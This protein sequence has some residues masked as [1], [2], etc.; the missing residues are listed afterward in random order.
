MFVQ[1]KNWIAGNLANWRTANMN[2]L[3]AGE[4]E[5]FGGLPGKSRHG[6]VVQKTHRSSRTSKDGDGKKKLGLRTT[7]SSLFPTRIPQCSPSRGR[8]SAQ[9][10]NSSSPS[11]SVDN[12]RATSISK[13]IIPSPVIMTTE[14]REKNRIV[15]SSPERKPLV[16]SCSSSLAKSVAV[17][18]IP[19]PKSSASLD[20]IKRNQF[21]PEARRVIRSHSHSSSSPTASGI[22]MFKEPSRP[23]LEAAD[24][25][26]SSPMRQVKRSQTARDIPIA[27]RFQEFG[28]D[29]SHN[30][31]DYSSH[32]PH[33]LVSATYRIPNKNSI[34][35]FDLFKKENK[36]DSFSDISYD[37]ASK[38]DLISGLPDMKLQESKP[39]APSSPVQD[40]TREGVSKVSI[41]IQVA[42][43]K[44][45]SPIQVEGALEEERFPHD[46]ERRLSEDRDFSEKIKELNALLVD[47]EKNSKATSCDVQKDTPKAIE[48][49]KKETAKQ[50]SVKDKSTSQK[51]S[52]NRR[53]RKKSK[54]GQETS[55]VYLNAFEDFSDVRTRDRLMKGYN[56]SSSDEE[57]APNVQKADIRLRNHDQLHALHR[58]RREH[59]KGVVKDKD[60]VW[61]NCSSRTRAS[62]VDRSEFFYRFGEKEK[63]AVASFDFLDQLCTSAVSSPVE[64]I[65]DSLSC[66]IM[67]MEDTLAPE[68]LYEELDFKPKILEDSP[69]NLTLRAD[70]KFSELEKLEEQLKKT[71]LNGE[72]EVE[73]VST[74]NEKNHDTWFNP[75]LCET[76]EQLIAALASEGSSV[77]SQV[78]RICLSDSCA[79]SIYGSDSERS[80]RS[81]ENM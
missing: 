10:S 17:S 42:V 71:I 12:V 76:E 64:E 16:K 50:K 80:L 26:Q 60:V 4:A 49:D 78:G 3:E 19:Q 15:K 47:H 53:S 8:S 20:Q 13:S 28:C 51:K 32:L 79:E 59:K 39:E 27:R 34:L 81:H 5:L 70:D 73:V 58:N 37:W 69:K 67:D 66:F 62:I 46:L 22:G 21:S 14:S 61:I 54:K 63:E 52:H 43:E 40:K 36:S 2:G 41:G 57:P 30:L 77:F 9:S 56:S 31:G 11:R 68:A 74:L 75:L 6:K 44:I 45:A 33:S 29:F 35:N 18:R 38:T 48:E 72:P 24:T 25:R 55:W 23:P 65:I 1:E 7:T